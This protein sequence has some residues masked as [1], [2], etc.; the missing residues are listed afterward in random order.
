MLDEQDTDAAFPT[1]SFSAPSLPPQATQGLSQLAPSANPNVPQHSMAPPQQQQAE[2]G[3]MNANFEQYD[4]ILDADPFG[5]S[6]TMGIGR[7]GPLQGYDGNINA[8][9]RTGAWSYR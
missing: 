3:A 1:A 5:L 8:L 9:K 4:P 7:H 6:A 2:V